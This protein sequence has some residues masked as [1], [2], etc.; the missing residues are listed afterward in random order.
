MVVWFGILLVTCTIGK[1]L[2]LERG[3][4]EFVKME[5][6][7]ESMN[8]QQKSKRVEREIT[9]NNNNSTTHKPLAIFRQYG[10]QYLCSFW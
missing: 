5:E 7:N 6:R 8:V 2:G 10:G 3:V 1:G 9:S 4:G